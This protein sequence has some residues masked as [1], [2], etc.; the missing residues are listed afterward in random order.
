MVSDDLL[1]FTRRFFASCPVLVREGGMR[2]YLT[3]FASSR[4]EVGGGG[5]RKEAG[6]VICAASQIPDWAQIS[7]SI[8]F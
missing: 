5:G 3:G 7:Y 6:G 8:F 4:L 2:I 1:E